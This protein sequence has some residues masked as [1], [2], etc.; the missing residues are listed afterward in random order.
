MPIRVGRPPS[1]S[2]IALPFAATACGGGG[3]DGGKIV[4]G[5]KFD[6]PGLGLKN[7]DGTMSGFDV[8]VAK[9]VAKELG[10]SPR[11]RSSGR[12]S[13]SR[14]ARDADPE[15]S[16]RVHRR[17]LLDHRRPQGEGRLRRART[18]SPGRACWYAR[19]N[20]DITGAESL[21]NNKKLCSVSGSTPA[22]RIKDKYPE[23][24]AAAV[25]HLLGVRRGA[26]ERCRSTR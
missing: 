26:E 16:G 25:R 13:P 23:R 24:A 3:D 22:Q 18:C 7:P 17:D 2:P 5:T 8:D 14:A 10:Y 9:Y 4:I 15:R 20:T 19:D 11:T 1:R 12:K 6:Q 21:E